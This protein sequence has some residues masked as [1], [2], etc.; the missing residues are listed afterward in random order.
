MIKKISKLHCI[1]W[2]QAKRSHVEQVRLLLESGADWVQLRQKEG[3][4]AQHLEVALECVALCRARGA[5]LIINDHVELCQ[6]CGADG[7]HLGL[8]DMPLEQA[9]AILGPDAIVG[10]TANTPEQ[11]LQRWHEG[12]DYVGL[13][14]WRYTG[15]KANLSPLLGAKG[16][17]HAMDSLRQAGAFLPVVVIGG[18]QPLDVPVIQSLGAYGVAVSSALVDSDHVSE[19]FQQFIQSFH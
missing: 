14:P 9:R 15:T 11:V 19:S 4:E 1:T 12:A 6:Q 17:S 5:T 2:D 10:G 13:G 8:M 3:S 7:V 16:V 18:V